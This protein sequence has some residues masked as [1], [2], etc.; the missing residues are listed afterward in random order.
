MEAGIGLGRLNPETPRPGNGHP[1]DDYSGL[2]LCRSGS[3][4]CVWRYEVRGTFCGVCAVRVWFPGDSL[5]GQG[6]WVRPPEGSYSTGAATGTAT[7]RTAAK[8]GRRLTLPGPETMA[9]FLSSA[10]RAEVLASGSPGTWVL[11]GEDEDGERHGRNPSPWIPQRIGYHLTRNG[12][13]Y[14]T[15]RG[16]YGINGVFIS[17]MKPWASANAV[18]VHCCEGMRRDPTTSRVFWYKPELVAWNSAPSTASSCS[19]TCAYC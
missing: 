9:N 11:H 17:G 19:W 15:V 12:P 16:K 1:E 4:L 10:L 2:R 5:A 8:V 13:C 6:C 14:C 3:R 7:P 18:T